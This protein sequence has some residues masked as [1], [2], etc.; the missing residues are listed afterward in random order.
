[1]RFL[2]GNGFSDPWL[3][4]LNQGERIL[5]LSTFAES[6]RR[7]EF[8]TRTLTCLRASTV[9]SAVSDIRTA[10]RS[11]FRDDPGIESGKMAI[12]LK[13]QLDGYKNED[14][15]PNHQKALPVRIFN[16]LLNNFS[17]KTEEAIG[18]MMT[19]AFFFAMRSCEY[20]S[21]KVPGR[22]GLIRLSDIRFYKN[23]QL[24]NIRLDTIERDAT[25]VTI[26]F[27]NQKNGE[28]GA[29][30]SQHRKNISSFLS[31]LKRNLPSES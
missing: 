13:R 4:T 28:K 17:T 19:T 31:R 24:L 18:Q 22:A 16:Y 6:V 21:V 12:I 3:D 25:S 1:M 29:L 15:S 23:K 26:T 8:G 10:F 2:E 27:R 9:S 20:N 30:V 11:N 5:L 7:N 14:P